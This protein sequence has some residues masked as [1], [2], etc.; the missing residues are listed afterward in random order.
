VV[1]REIVKQKIWNQISVLEKCGKE[2]PPVLLEYYDAI[3]PGDPTNRE[4][5][6][7]KVDE[8]I[9]RIVE[10][11]HK[12]ATEKLNEYK[13]ALENMARLLIERETI[14]ATEVDML[15][16]GKSLD[17]IREYIKEQDQK[18]EDAKKDK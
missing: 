10:D 7:A 12:V 15:V 8:E 11:C 2:I 17:E 9:R 5:L 13:F 1:W 18:I 14:Y 6:A 3:E 16:E 4:A